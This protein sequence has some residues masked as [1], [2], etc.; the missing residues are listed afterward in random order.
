MKLQD[1]A[2]ILI[3]KG[4]EVAPVFGVDVNFNCFCGN[5]NCFKNGKHLY[6]FTNKDFGTKNFQM[7]KDNI[8]FHYSANIAVMTG[9]RSELVI[10]DVDLPAFGNGAFDLIAKTTPELEKTFS[11]Q[12]GSGGIHFYFK[13]SN[14][15]ISR[16]NQF[17]EGIDLLAENA[18]AVSIGSTH[19]CGGKYR[20]LNDTKVI[21][22]PVSLAIKAKSKEGNMKQIA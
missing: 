5:S 1:Q 17:G 21:D 2:Q 22:F 13:T 11:V 19:K 6:N 4:F 12:S 20:I 3:S 14:R 9:R 10:V 8:R 7:L 18:Y 15:F 16:T